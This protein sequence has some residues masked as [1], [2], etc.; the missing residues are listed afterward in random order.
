VLEAIMYVMQT[1]CGWQ[2]LPAAFPPWKTVYA[3][4]TQWRKKGIWDSIWAGLDKP[5]PADELQL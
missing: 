3:Q 2:H 4:Y 1:N 5:L